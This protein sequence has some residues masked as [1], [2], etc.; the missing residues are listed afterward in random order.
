MDNI[1]NGMITGM[2]QMGAT[3]VD[4]RDGFIYFNIKIG[5]EID[6]DQKLI[7]ASDAFQK[8]GLVVKIRWVD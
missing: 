1:I 2:C 3:L 6:N 4:I 7:R 5:S 8:F